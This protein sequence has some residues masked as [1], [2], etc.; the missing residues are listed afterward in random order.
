HSVVRPAKDGDADNTYCQFFVNV[1]HRWDPFVLC[2][3][4]RPTT[5]GDGY[6][7]VGPLEHFH[8]A[9]VH[10]FTHYLDHPAVHIPIINGTL[11]DRVIPSR[12]QQD[13]LAR[14]PQ[15]GSPECA[16]QIQTLQ[17]TAKEFSNVG[18]DLEGLATKG[19]EFYAAAKRAAEACRGLASN[20]LA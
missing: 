5:W 9:N 3:P 1:W 19:A 12:E 8:Q 15:I 17:D 13:A 10:G 18:D 6:F 7:P 14:Y 20:L 11:G 2:G 16:A 4:F